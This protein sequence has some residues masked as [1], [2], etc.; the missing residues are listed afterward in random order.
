MQY[1]AIE[2]RWRC[3]MR[4]ATTVSHSLIPAAAVSSETQ[5]CIAI[6]KALIRDAGESAP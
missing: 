6:L 4:P 1:L 3:A 2:L 5:E